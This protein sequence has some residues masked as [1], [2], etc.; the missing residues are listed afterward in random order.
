MIAMNLRQLMVR[1]GSCPRFVTAFAPV[2]LPWFT[3][4]LF[5]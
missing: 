1:P 4:P 2:T 3:L 5:V